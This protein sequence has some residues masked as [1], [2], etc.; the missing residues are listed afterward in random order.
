M[1]MDQKLKKIAQQNLGMERFFTGDFSVR[2]SPQT[3]P[4]CQQTTDRPDEPAAGLEMI[5]GQ[6]RQCRKCQIGLTRTNAVPGEGNPVARLVFVGEGPGAD[7]DAQGRPFVGRAGQLLD[8]MIIA[9]GLKRGD[10]FIC[11]IIKCRPPENR[12]PKPDE[13]FNCFPY[14]KEQLA[15]IQPEII[16]ALGKP[17]ANTLLENDTAIGKLRGIFHEYHYSPDCPPAKLMPTY[18][19]AYLLRS[20]SPENRQRVWDDLQKVMKELGMQPRQQ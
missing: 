16:V 14:L 10:V 6:V 12:D 13:V 11:N 9:M 15:L 8:K 4:C 18:H 5:A 3:E 2:K 7:E 1:L 20:Y 17:A 19:P